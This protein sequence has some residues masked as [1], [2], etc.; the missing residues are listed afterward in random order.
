[1]SLGYV[2][3]QIDKLHILERGEV[4][5]FFRR[6]EAGKYIGEVSIRKGVELDIAA[7][8]KKIGLPIEYDT[9]TFEDGRYIPWY[10]ITK[11]APRIVLN[12]ERPE[13]SLTFA[14]EVGHHFL[15]GEVGIGGHIVNSV[16]ERVGEAFC[17]F[18]GYKMA[19]MEPL[20]DVL[21][22]KHAKETYGIPDDY[23]K[24]IND[25]RLQVNGRM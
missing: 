7:T 4:A 22:E 23:E 24:F 10:G 20:D 11:P 1:M 15:D 17:E 21:L 6:T 25:M 2:R 14:H 19:M 12:P 16:H 5:E 8:A 9:T 3:P 18:F 13:L